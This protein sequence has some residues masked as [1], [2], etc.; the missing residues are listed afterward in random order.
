MQRV[1]QAAKQ[2]HYSDEMK[3]ILA[4][5]HMDHTCWQRWDQYITRK[6]VTNQR[7]LY[8]TWTHFVK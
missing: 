4:T 3:I 8:N 2:T 5:N 6:E 7:E 1:F